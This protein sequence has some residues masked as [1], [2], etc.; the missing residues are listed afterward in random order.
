MELVRCVF[1]D[2]SCS[3]L[4]TL[5][6]NVSFDITNT[7]IFCWKNVN[8][9]L[10]ILTCFQQKITVYFDNVVHIYLTS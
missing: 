6:V 10:K 9:L 1:Q 2:P 8:L 3:T 4:T 5:L 7:V